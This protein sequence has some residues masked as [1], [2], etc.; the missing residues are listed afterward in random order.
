MQ[1][2]DKVLKYIVFIG[3]FLVPLIPFFV[4]SSQVFPFITGKNFSFRVIVGVTFFAWL[5]LAFLREEYRPKKTLLLGSVTVFVGIMF[6]ANIFGVEPRQSFWS[7]FERMEGWVTLVHLLAYVIVLGSFLKT[8]ELWKRFWQTSVV[9]SFV[10]AL[11]GLAQL[12]RAYLVKDLGRSADEGLARLLPIINQGGDRL[13]A[14]FGNA[15][16]LAVYMM[17]HIFITTAFL[18]RFRSLSTNMKIFFSGALI[19]QL[20]TLYHTATRGAILGLIGGAIITALILFFSENKGTLVKKASAGLLAVIIIFGGVFF[21]SRDSNFVQSQPTLQRLANISL[22]DKTTNSRFMMW[23]IAFKGFKERPILGYGQENFNYVFNKH[24][25]PRMYDHEQ[26]FDRTH[27]VVFDWLI[28]GGILGFL[29]YALIILA[30]LRSVWKTEKL[31]KREKAIFVGMIVGYVFQNMFVF[32]QITSY[33]IFFAFVAY[34]H[35]QSG[36]KNLFS[37]IFEISEGSRDR[38]AV[39]L[40]IVFMLVVPYM[41][42]ASGYFQSR[43]AIRAMTVRPAQSMQELQGNVQNSLDLF[44]KALNYDSFGTAEIRERLPEVTVQVF[45]VEQVRAD[46]KE[47]FFLLTRQELEEQ[48]EESPLDARYYLIMGDFLMRFSQIEQAV[49]FLEKAVELSPNKQSIRYPLARGYALLGRNNEALEQMRIAYDLEA[50]NDFAWMQYALYAG[51]AN[52]FELYEQLIDEALAGEYY[53]RVIDLYR[54]QLPANQ[55][56][57]ELH[58]DL[59]SVYREAGQPEAARGVLQEMENI[60]DGAVLQEVRRLQAEF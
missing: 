52:E 5:A 48:I 13:D 20:F 19:L 30:L 15:T 31:S 49:S 56:N 47:Q 39:P 59:V 54:N 34:I 6:F 4:D 21:V 18:L 50:D 51:V 60:F 42:N 32:D 12:L 45:S 43:T 35:S 58:F 38:L 9:A 14:T 16:Y 2:L 36:G 22:D 8:K 26:W 11:Y 24:Y 10:V 7:N 41:V 57:S 40:L 37:K 29:A 3:I 27:N 44:K 33:I 1:G 53:Q 28:A 17:L 25:N 55:D 46:L 23:D